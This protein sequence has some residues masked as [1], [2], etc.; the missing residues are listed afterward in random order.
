MQKR[1]PSERHELFMDPRQHKME[2]ALSQLC[3]LSNPSFWEIFG[4][5]KET[6]DFKIQIKLKK[7]VFMKYIEH[8]NTDIR[9]KE[10]Y[11]K[12]SSVCG[13]YVKMVLF[14]EFFPSWIKDRTQIEEREN[15]ESVFMSI[16][17]IIKTDRENFDEEMRQEIEREN[18][19]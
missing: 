15:V 9:L 18:L 6:Y 12:S 7:N 17:A 16:G 13:K 1:T 8:K 3:S 2:H 4:D 5:N 19:S 14:P 11:E 10:M